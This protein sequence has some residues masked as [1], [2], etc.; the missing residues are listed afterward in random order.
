MAPEI[1]MLLT[2][3]KASQLDAVR[4]GVPPEWTAA[5]VAHAC[6]GLDHRAYCA[7]SYRWARDDSVY[8]ALFAALFLE[9]DLLAQHE[10]WPRRTSAGA[11]YLQTLVR[12]ALF[13]ERHGVP[14]MLSR[15]TPVERQQLFGQD[16]EAV[17]ELLR[18]G[19]TGRLRPL[20]LAAL[21]E[22]STDVWIVELERR[23]EGIRGIFESWCARARSHVIAHIGDE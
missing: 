14:Y 17:N 21:A 13:E 22:V 18:E 16:P 8:A 11:R 5:D 19:L 9:A 7:F 10:R 12:L 6:K 3:P 15:M 20:L 2:A 1:L 23:Y 4:T